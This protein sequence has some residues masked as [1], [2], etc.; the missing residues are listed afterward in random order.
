MTDD[1]PAGIALAMAMQRYHRAMVESAARDELE[2][3]IATSDETDC[4][5]SDADEFCDGG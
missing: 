1:T 4:D 3:G 5:G 2:A